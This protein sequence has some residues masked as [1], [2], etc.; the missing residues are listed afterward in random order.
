[1]LLL[2]VRILACLVGALTVQNLTSSNGFIKQE[3]STKYGWYNLNLRGQLS[4]SSSNMLAAMWTY[5]SND[6]FEHL[7]SLMK[8]LSDLQKQLPSVMGLSER[9]TSLTCVTT[10]HSDCLLVN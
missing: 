1:M 7:N 6:S 3:R 4:I 10:K 9:L 8:V 5:G 2:W